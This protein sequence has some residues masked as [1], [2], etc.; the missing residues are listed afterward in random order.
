[1]SE[2]V[3]IAAGSSP[4]IAGDSYLDGGDYME[5]LALTYDYSYSQLTPAQRTAW[6]T[7]ADQTI[8]NARNHASAQWGGVSR[9]WSGWFVSDPG[10]NYFYSFM[11]AT[12]LWSLA[13][14]NM[15]WIKYLQTNKYTILI[16]YF[17]ALPGGGSREGT[18]YGTSLGSLFENYAY[19]KSST[20]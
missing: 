6:A 20:G 13:S 18:G 17:Y 2:N 8:N 19:W 10:D 11:K 7:Y 3:L 15:T 4:V 12:Q 9:P 1:T 16:P 14:Q 5:Q